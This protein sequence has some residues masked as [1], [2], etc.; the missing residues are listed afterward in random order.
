MFPVHL[1]VDLRARSVVAHLG[2]LLPGVT[3]VP[4]GAD[5]L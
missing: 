3:R 2:F 5:Y 4:S 1:S